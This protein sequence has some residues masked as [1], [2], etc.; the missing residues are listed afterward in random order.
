MCC[1]ST[2]ALILEKDNDVLTLLEFLDE[3]THLIFHQLDILE[4]YQNVRYNLNTNQIKHIVVKLLSVIIRGGD[5]IFYLTNTEFIKTLKWSDYKNNKS[6]INNKQFFKKALTIKHTFM[7]VPNYHA[8]FKLSVSQPTLFTTNFTSYITTK[9]PPLACSVIR[10]HRDRPHTT[11]SNEFSNV[12]L[13]LS[14]VKMSVSSDLLEKMWELAELDMKYSIELV[15]GMDKLAHLNLKQILEDILNIIKVTSKHI[16][17]GTIKAN[18]IKEKAKNHIQNNKTLEANIK[19]E[20]EYSQKLINLKKK[21]DSI[22]ISSIYEDKERI[23]FQKIFS[24]FYQYY[25]FNKFIE[26]IKTN[27]IN[28][29]YFLTYA[30][31]R[32]RFYYD[33][34]ASPQSFWGF[35]HI[36]KCENS[37]FNAEIYYHSIG[38]LFKKEIT[39][40]DGELQLNKLAALGLDKYNTLG[41]L[42]IAQ[43]YNDL[44]DLTLIAEFIYYK[45]ALTT[46]NETYFIWRDTTCSMAQHAVKLLGFKENTLKYVNLDNTDVA[47]DTYTI[48]IRELKKFLKK[49]GWTD[50]QLDFLS[51][52]LLK[53]VIMTVGYGVTFF[54]AYNRHRSIAADMFSDL[55]V[56][57][58]ITDKGVFKEIY[59]AL[60]EGQLDELFYKDTKTSWVNK[61][62]LDETFN[63]PDMKLPQFYLLPSIKLTNLELNPIDGK[64][65]HHQVSV[66]YNYNCDQ[67]LYIKN[68]KG[69]DIYD[70]EK[71]K[72]ALYVNTIHALDAYYMRN[73][74]YETRRRGHQIIAVHDGFAVPPHQ[75]RW[76]ISTANLIFNKPNQAFS[77]SNSILI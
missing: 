55:K 48:Y 66:H 8:L 37:N 70:K 72:R 57:K 12:L 61:Q 50:D 64:R 39:S 33:S 52:G 77:H 62:K 13:L 73:L 67:E 16:S 38:V 41:K 36:Y 3:V 23:I 2:N 32:G 9:F 49:S 45:H 54:T 35:R 4:T 20:L 56:F 71:T 43:L 29:W 51:R 65:Q 22:L 63:L 46:P 1:E 17:V 44:K 76:L 27:N 74:I 69:D 10:Q 25:I 47:Y 40:A 42:T 31:F 26:Y 19:D 7:V 6:F 34:L 59:T 60:T 53:H 11:Y 18:F 28:S 68:I 30:D 15:A 24:K 21:W 5:S 58:W 75:G 14:Q